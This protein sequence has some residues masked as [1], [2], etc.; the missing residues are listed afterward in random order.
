MIYTVFFKDP[1]LMPYDAST[2]KEAE[3]YAKEKNSEYTIE[4]I[5][6]DCE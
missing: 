6:G 1:D 3:D 5:E 4:S 2:Y